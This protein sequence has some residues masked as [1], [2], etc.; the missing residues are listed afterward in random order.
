MGMRKGGRAML[1]P[2]NYQ[3]DGSTLSLDFTAMGG[4]LD[5]RLTFSRASTAT[6]VNSSGYVAYADTNL[7]ANS[8]FSG[9]SQPTNWDKTTTWDGIVSS[10]GERRVTTDATGAS[11]YLACPIAIQP[12]LTY[13]A[14][15]YVSEVSG[16]H[17]ANTITPTGSAVVSKIYRNGVNVGS[18]YNTA[19]PGLITTVFSQPSGTTNSIRIGLGCTGSAIINGVCQFSQPRCV[20]GD[21]PQPTYFASPVATSYHAPRFD[22]SPTNIG[23]PRGL[24]IEGSSI[25]YMLQSTTLSQTAFSMRANTTASITDPEG[26]TTN[27]KTVGADGTYNYHLYYLPTTAG[28]NTVVTVSIFAKKNGYKYLYL[29]DVTSGRSAVRFDLDNGTTSNSA[30]AGFASATATP[31][32]NGWWR[33]SMVANVVASTSYGWSY[34]GVPTTGASLNAFGAAY[35]GANTDSDGIYCYGFQVEAGSGASSYIPTGASQVTRNTDLLAVTSTTTMGLNTSEGTFFVETELPRAGTT[36]PSQFGT[37]YANGSWL[38]QFY[39]G[40]EATTLTA[41][42]WGGSVL[43]LSR[44]G[45]PKSLTALSYGL[46]TGA[47]IPVSSSLNGALSTGTFTTS[48]ANNAPNPATWNFITLACNASSLA[49]T[50]RDNLNACIKRFKYFPT[51]LTN[52]QLQTLTTP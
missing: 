12:G 40:A 9:T 47:S 39:G 44:S 27:A 17:Y 42:W 49:T 6:F 26:T 33:C 38:G 31:Y 24:L 16:Q 28:T 35:T 2:S 48:G 32:P 41:N 18:I 8:Q 15:V 11:K 5:P 51:R 30:G 25:N 7:F 36:S 13:S 4:V 3:G 23:E 50:S 43:P 1:M 22:Y 29:S 34:G 21:V 20:P 46:Y 19:E 10:P 45:N 37:P 52:A 14:S